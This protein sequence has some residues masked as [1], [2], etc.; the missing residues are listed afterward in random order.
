ME[1]VTHLQEAT[2]WG[3]RE[4]NLVLVAERN[5]PP[6]ALIGRNWR[7]RAGQV[8]VATGAIERSLVFAQQ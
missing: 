1:N 6:E 3:Y 4:H 8:I 5:P 7:V 2:V